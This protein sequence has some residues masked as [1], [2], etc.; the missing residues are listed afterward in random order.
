MEERKGTFTLPLTP[1]QQEEIRNATGRHAETLE[2]SIK[3]LEE[4]LLPAMRWK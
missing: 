1:Q 2:F 4:R 3:E